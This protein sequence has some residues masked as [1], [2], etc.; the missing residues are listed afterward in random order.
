MFFRKKEYH[1]S[2]IEKMSVSRY[3]N[4]EMGICYGL[5]SVGLQAILLRDTA[6]FDE[7]IN[8]LYDIP[9]LGVNYHIDAA[10]ESWKKTMRDIKLKLKPFRN[11]ADYQ[12]KVT[13]ESQNA[14]QKLSKREKVLLTANSFFDSVAVHQ[15]PDEYANLFPKG[16]KVH[17]QELLTSEMIVLPEALEKQGKIALA[18]SFCGAYTINEIHQLLVSLRATIKAANLQFPVGMVLCSYNHAFTIGLDPKSDKWMLIEANTGPTQ[19]LGDYSLAKKINSLFSLN[20]ITVFNTT[21]YTTRNNLAAVKP[22]INQWKSTPAFIGSHGNLAVRAEYQDSDTA[23]MLYVAAQNGQTETVKRLLQAGA[24]VNFA[25][26]NTPSPLY[27]AAYCG[28]TEVVKELLNHGA[29]I[30]ADYYT[31][32]SP[33]IAAAKHRH[34]ETVKVLLDHGAD[35]FEIIRDTEVMKQLRDYK[36]ISG[37][38]RVLM[39]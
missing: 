31:G 37:E 30:H 20:K 9:S 16:Y 26:Y 8:C 6:T 39:R 25:S 3:R 35:L 22:V 1:R 27:I 34:M 18:D 11:D 36:N 5:A 15:A 33:L 29:Y 2:I 13:E 21:I 19:W 12:V 14:W 23:T 32:V 7:R 38:Q 17:N 24:N 28:H 10:Q 4:V